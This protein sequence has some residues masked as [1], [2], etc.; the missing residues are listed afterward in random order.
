MATAICDNVSTS[1][2]LLVWSKPEL[3]VKDSTGHANTD[4]TDTKLPPA[5]VLPAPATV[6]TSEVK[7]G[8][9][10]NGIFNSNSGSGIEAANPGV[11]TVPKKTSNQAK[12]TEP[13]RAN[14]CQVSST[15]SEFFC[16]N[17]NTI[18]DEFYAYCS[19]LT[20][21]KK[22]ARRGCVNLCP[23]V[24]ESCGSGTTGGTY[25]AFPGSEDQLDGT[26]RG[27]CATPFRWASAKCST[28]SSRNSVQPGEASIPSKRR[29][30][31]DDL[32]G[33]MDGL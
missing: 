26:T 7:L 32:F 21:G 31:G 16:S 24:G 2:S 27:Y 33:E 30:D 6:E 3:C 1:S 15:T 13:V 11:K 8:S 22:V 18:C 29:R 28:L 17:P 14:K 5:S 4:A 23:Y 12:A 25:V 20:P 19:T 10:I 9:I